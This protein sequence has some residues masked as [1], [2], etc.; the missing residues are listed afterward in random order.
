MTAAEFRL[1]AVP[2]TENLFATA[3]PDAVASGDA[4]NPRGGVPGGKDRAHAK[5]RPLHSLPTD[6]VKFEKQIEAIRRLAQMSGPGKRPVSSEDLAHALEL[7]ANTAGLCVGFFRDS[8]WVT[9]VSR[10]NYVATDAAWDYQH[11]LSLD[12]RGHTAALRHLVEPV[13]KSWYWQAIE[14]MLPGG[15]PQPVLLRALS[16]AANAH[17]HRAQLLLILDWLGWLGLVHRSGDMIFPVQDAAN[18]NDLSDNTN[19][20]KDSHLP[21]DENGS[22]EMASSSKTETPSTQP[23]QVEGDVA[24]MI[25]F[26]L[27]VRITAEDAARLSPE[28]LSSLVDV[29]QRLRG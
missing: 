15:A 9:K 26:S 27:N 21:M 8:G 18:P 3:S 14:P 16:K 28:Q 17:D 7:S 29:V 2:D 10:G 19:P 22:P 6:R 11:D 1:Q 23:A 20:Q 4:G 25:S 24:S 12:E 13:K 5:Q